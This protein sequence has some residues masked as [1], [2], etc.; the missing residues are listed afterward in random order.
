MKQILTPFTVPPMLYAFAENQA[1][2]WQLP[3][4]ISRNDSE[5]LRIPSH[6][7]PKVVNQK[8]RAVR[9]ARGVVGNDVLWRFNRLKL[10][11]Q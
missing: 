4:E 5:S 2:A 3:L 9:I 1:A 10:R 7:S 8:L 11:S 6:V